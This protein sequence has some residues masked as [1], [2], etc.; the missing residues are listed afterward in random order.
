MRHFNEGHC[1]ELT[2]MCCALGEGVIWSVVE[3]G[4]QEHGQG[5]QGGDDDKQPQKQAVHHQSDELPISCQLEGKHTHKST[6]R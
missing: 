3:A 1:S 5:S 2:G 6:L 4:V